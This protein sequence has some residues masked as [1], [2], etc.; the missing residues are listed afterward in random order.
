VLRFAS[1]SAFSMYAHSRSGSIG[2]APTSVWKIV[3]SSIASGAPALRSGAHSSRHSRTAATHSSA[4]PA[5]EPIRARTSPDR[6]VSCVVVLN[7]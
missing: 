7:R 6:F 3:Y 1:R 5:S 4:I 2:H